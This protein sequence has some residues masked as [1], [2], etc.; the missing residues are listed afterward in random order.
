MKAL[1]FKHL[2][3][4]KPSFFATVLKNLSACLK[5]LENCENSPFQPSEFHISETFAFK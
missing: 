1:Y 2:N 5:E 4:L 3:Q